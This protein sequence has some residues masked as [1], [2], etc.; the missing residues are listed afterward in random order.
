[1]KRS[2]GVDVYDDGDDDK[3]LGLPVIQ[4]FVNQ[5]AC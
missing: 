3:H 4:S 1:M 5:I 2:A